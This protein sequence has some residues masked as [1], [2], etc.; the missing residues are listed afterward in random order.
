MN[1]KKWIKVEQN[2]KLDGT[3]YWLK[4][5]KKS[6]ILMVGDRPYC[7]QKFLLNE[8]KSFL[9]LLLGIKINV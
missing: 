4:K 6:F 1:N 8:A 2:Y 9:N 5:S 3:K 7:Q